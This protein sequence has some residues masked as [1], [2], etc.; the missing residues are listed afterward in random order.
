MTVFKKTSATFAAAIFLSAGFA[1]CVPGT[2]SAE[3][4]TVVTWNVKNTGV[5]EVEKDKRQIS[6]FSSDLQPDIIALQEIKDADAALAIATALGWEKFQ[7]AVSAFGTSQQ[8]LAVV[9]RLPILSAVE[10]DTKPDGKTHPIYSDGGAVGLPI[11]ETQLVSEGISNFGDPLSGHD[12]GT[13]RVDFENGLTLFVVHLKSDRNDVCYQAL[14]TV[15]FMEKYNIGLVD[16][17]RVIVRNGLNEATTIRIANAKKRERVAASIKRVASVAISEGRVPIVLGD[18]N[19][20]FE[21]GKH[22]EE[23]K[24]CV[25]KNFTCERVATPKGACDGHGYDD[26]LG[27]F[28]SGMVTPTRWVFLTAQLGRTWQRGK[29]EFS[30]YAIDHVTV[31]EA[32]R[33]RFSNAWKAKKQ[34]GSDHF[35]VMLEVEVGN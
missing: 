34:Y 22:G 15:K 29:P 4:I 31:P 24:D 20:T 14:K 32:F 18:F 11:N 25:L 5:D 33:A 6:E 12:K 35:P 26:T 7:L 13:L 3:E 16:Q 21:P 1:A 8:E 9:S 10:Y 2:S 19:T 27:I 17:M 23:A 28:T 30:D